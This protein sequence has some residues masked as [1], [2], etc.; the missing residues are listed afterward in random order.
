MCSALHILRD[1]SAVPLGHIQH[2]LCFLVFG[3]ESKLLASVLQGSDYVTLEVLLIKS[4]LQ[5]E[6][7]RVHIHFFFSKCWLREESPRRFPYSSNM[8]W[9]WNLF[10]QC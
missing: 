7:R 1:G 3:A 5:S 4:G 6:P 10:S 8:L 2:L 9:L